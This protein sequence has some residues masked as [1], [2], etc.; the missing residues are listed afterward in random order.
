MR[1]SNGSRNLDNLRSLR[2]VDL[3]GH[4]LATP[5]I[6]P[7]TNKTINRCSYLVRVP[8]SNLN[9]DPI[10]LKLCV[11]NIR[12]ARNKTADFCDYACSCRADIFALTET[13][14]NDIDTAHRIEL[15]PPGFNLSDHTRTQRRGGVTALL[16]RDNMQV[17]K[18]TADELNS[19]EL[20]E[21]MIVD[22]SQR[23]R[24][25]IVYRPPYSP[26][27]RVSTGIFL[28]ELAEYLESV[29]LAQTQR[30]KD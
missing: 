29:I 17:T 27:H 14:L 25:V 10:C 23:L 11:L 3:A 22:G 8:I 20:S 28:N 18:I 26:N 7:A 9:P 2:C 13:W 4:L 24:I 6:H 15:T 21:W 1:G 5:G 12:S 30:S 19:F 16:V